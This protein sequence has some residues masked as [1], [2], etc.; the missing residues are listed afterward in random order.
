MLEE[1]KRLI[2]YTIAPDEKVLVGL[3]GGADS[4]ALAHLLYSMGYQ[5]LPIHVNFHL[6]GE[7]SERDQRFVE[8]FCKT[9][10]PGITLA[11]SSAQT[12]AVAKGEGISIEMAAREIRYEVFGIVASE[13]QCQWITV[14][15][16]ADDQV[17]T[18]L[19]N[20]ARGTGG[21][22]L[23]GMRVV[24][25]NIFRPFLTTTRKEVLKYI[26]TQQLEYVTDSTNSDTEIKRNYIRHKLIPAFEVL[27]PSFRSSMLES[28]SHIE[29]EQLVLDEQKEI[30]ESRYVD[31]KENSIDLREAIHSTSSRYFFKRWVHYLGF[32]YAQAEDMLESSESKK[33]ISFRNRDALAQIYRSKLYIIGHE[34]EYKGFEP[35]PLTDSCVL[36]SLTIHKGEKRGT[37][38]LYIDNGYRDKE[39][40]VRM[41][42]H[43][44]MFRPF[45]M[46]QGRKSLFRYLGEKG[47][48]EF[49]RPFCP[50]LECDGEII[51][52]L[53]FDISE[54]ARATDVDSALVIGIET[55]S[56]QLGS[57]LGNLLSVI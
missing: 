29:E 52:A 51:A 2:R 24:N 11:I 36:D 5:I 47:V 26:E 28:M 43:E 33:S 18:A 56:T 15:H 53:P 30:F 21:N 14:A 19:L 38:I 13:K 39:L 40:L 48:P 22:G 50:V 23:A 27:N 35:I 34:S 46:K 7:E 54:M 6:R 10:F 45:G 57:I 9:H 25:G 55:S 32:N 8:E 41:G 44:D 20:L 17:E 4:I 3:S 31:V 12:E 42:K 16:H 1:A 49:Y 37:K